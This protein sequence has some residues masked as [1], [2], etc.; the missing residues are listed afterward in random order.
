MTPTPPDYFRYFTAAPD[1]ARWG[2]GL[3]AAGFTAIPAGAA[4]PPRWFA[5]DFIL[6]TPPSRARR[7]GES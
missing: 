1:I 5:S 6:R 7:L 2:V 4:Y 3:T